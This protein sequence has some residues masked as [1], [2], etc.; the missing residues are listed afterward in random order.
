MP[1]IFTE[2]ELCEKRI[3]ELKRI[4]HII[5]NNIIDYDNRRG[6]IW[7]F[8]LFSNDKEYIRHQH[9]IQ[10]QIRDELSII[11]RA[12]TLLNSVC[13]SVHHQSVD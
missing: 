8:T 3:K 10:K 5:E 1:K 2:H 12:Q 6:C 13:V 4:L 9:T 11:Q 7:F